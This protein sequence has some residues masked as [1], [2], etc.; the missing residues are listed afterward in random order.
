[1]ATIYCYAT[2]CGQRHKKKVWN[3]SED[4]LRSSKASALEAGWSEDRAGRMWCP[5]HTLK[6]VSVN[7]DAGAMPRVRILDLVAVSQRQITPEGYL[8]A[9]ARIARTGIQEYRAKELGIDKRGMPAAKIVRLYRPA[10]EVFAPPT[11]ASFDGAPI[12]VGHPAGGVDAKTWKKL[13][14]GEA[15]DVA[16]DGQ[17]LAAKL[18]VRDKAAI[19]DVV[20]GKSQL[21][22]GYEFD[23]D[24]TPGTTA[25][26]QA[27][28]GV[29]RN[30]SGNHIAI[31]DAGRAG[32]GVRIADN[33][34]DKEQTMKIRIQDAQGKNLNIEVADEATAQLVL[35]AVDGH[36]SALMKARDAYDSMKQACDAEKK[37]ADELELKHE[38]A[39]KDSK[40]KAGDDAAKIATLEAEVASLKAVDHQAIA[41]ER[42]KLIG[43][44]KVILGA[45]FDAKGKT[46]DA[47]RALA[48]DK[49]AGNGA[50]AKAV[51]AAV[52]GETKVS[53]AKPEF[54]KM[55]FDTIVGL[56]TT[57]AKKDPKQAARDAETARA[58]AG[59]SRKDGTDGR[60][61][62]VIKAE[63]VG[64]AGLRSRIGN[65]PSATA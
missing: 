1:M 55:A 65:K 10:E 40:K 9:P 15:R 62:T 52:I 34:N 57:A 42:A 47:I 33:Q 59:N 29:Q 44:A 51:V 45:D 7:D 54:V 41:D 25:D 46:N 22:C 27:Y 6:R 58:L 12:T 48:V 26:G 3:A 43:D 37:R 28:D 20:N 13:A 23:L 32:P 5:K 50:A 63:D 39:E 24:M 8:V 49:A 36:H 31:V 53:D 30:I 14:V 60:A 21:S 19:D 38:K 35:D 61:P 11:I 18:T 17:F 2:G 4:A 64:Q 56:G 16:A